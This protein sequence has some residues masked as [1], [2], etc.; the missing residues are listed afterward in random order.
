[1]RITEKQIF[2]LIDVLKDSLNIRDHFYINLEQRTKLYTCLLNQQ[3]D[4]LR[5]IKDDT[6]N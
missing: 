2:V 6:A 3:S 5:E 1:M 4:L